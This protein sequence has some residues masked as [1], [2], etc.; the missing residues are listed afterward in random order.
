MFPALQAWHWRHSQRARE[1]ARG[2][3]SSAGSRGDLDYFTSDAEERTMGKKN[4]YAVAKGR[5]T[6]IFCSW[7]ECSAQVNGC[8]SDFKGFATHAEAVAFLQ[9]RGVAVDASGAA[10]SQ[11]LGPNGG[12]AAA[13]HGAGGGALAGHKRFRDDE[14]APASLGIAGSGLGATQV[15]PYVPGDA[16]ARQAHMLWFDGGSRGNGSAGAVAGSGAVMYRDDI[17]VWE[18]GHYLG[19]TT[20]NVAEY[21]GLL[22]GLEAAKKLGVSMLKVRSDS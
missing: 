11:R 3:G 10:P 6:G 12:V 20:N 22:L 1:E 14:P 21:S 13:Q 19:C 7:A 5:Q 15:Q 2:V 18:G 17:K 16:A 8:A 4:F 9:S